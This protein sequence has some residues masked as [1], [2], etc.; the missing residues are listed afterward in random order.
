LYAEESLR[1]NVLVSVNETGEE[2]KL[3]LEL[4]YKA[5]M[6]NSKSVKEVFNPQN[7]LHESAI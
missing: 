5:I 1:G 2:S 3:D 6:T 7:Q 4:L